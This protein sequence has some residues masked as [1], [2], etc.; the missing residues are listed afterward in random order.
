MVTYFG[1][2]WKPKLR[3][4]MV[5]LTGRIRIYPEVPDMTMN[6]FTAR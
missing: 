1:K 2:E 4:R 5:N 6:L 3:Q